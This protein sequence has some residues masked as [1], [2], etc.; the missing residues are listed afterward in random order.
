MAEVAE[1]LSVAT[2][3]RI[4]Y[5]DVPPDT[6]HELMV[7]KGLPAPFAEFL[8]AFYGLVRDGATDFV[9]E[10]V[11]EVTGAPGRTFGAFAEEHASAFAGKVG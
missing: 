4:R 7:E 11:S 6:A 8:V 1:K 5:E 2:G 10:T 9:T 3:R